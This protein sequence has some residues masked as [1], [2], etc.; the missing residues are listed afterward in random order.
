MQ[1]PRNRMSITCPKGLQNQ[2]GENNCFLNSAVQVLWH[3]DVFR[4][5]FRILSGHACVGH[6]CIFCALKVIFTQFQYSDQTVLPPDQLRKALADTFLDQQRFQVGDM[7]DAAECFENILYQIH[8]H[9]ANKEPEDRCKAPHCVSHQKFGMSIVEQIICPCGAKNEPFA[10]NQLVLYVPTS[11][12][13]SQAKSLIESEGSYFDPSERFS[14]LVGRAMRSGDVRDCPKSCGEKVLLN[15]S[16]R[17]CPDVVSVGLVWDTDRPS[18]NYIMDIGELIGTHLKLTDLYNHV[19]NEYLHETT[20]E[21]VGVVAYYGKHYS[22]F[23]RHTH[24]KRWIYFDDAAIQEVGDQWQAVIDKCC[25]S[26]YQPLLLLYANPE[27]TVVNTHTAPQTTTIVPRNTFRPHRRNHSRSSSVDSL[28]SPSRG[29]GSSGASSDSTVKLADAARRAITP[30]PWEIQKHSQVN[31]PRRRA[32]TPGPDDIKRHANDIDISNRMN[33]HQRQGSF[34]FAVDNNLEPREIALDDDASVQSYQT[35][36]FPPP[37]PPIDENWHRQYNSQ[38]LSPR[39]GSDAG[40]SSSDAGISSGRR[41]KS[42]GRQN[43]TNGNSKPP[44]PFHQRKMKLKSL[45]SE[46]ART[47]NSSTSS[48]ENTNVVSGQPPKSPGI[49][50]KLFSKT[51]DLVRKESFKKNKDKVHA[52]IIRFHMNGAEEARSSPQQ[53]RIA[54]KSNSSENLLSSSRNDGDLRRG[55]KLVSRAQSV[56]GNLNCFDA[57]ADPRSVRFAADAWTRPAGRTCDDSS[58][59]QPSRTYI[60]NG[61]QSLPRPKRSAAKASKSYSIQK[62]DQPDG[63]RNVVIDASKSMSRKNNGPASPDHKNYISRNT[64]EA[65]LMRQGVQAKTAPQG[66]PRS[67]TTTAHRH[68]NALKVVIPERDD[69]SLDSQKDSG[70][71]SGGSAGDRSSASSMSVDSPTTAPSNNGQPHYQQQQQQ[72]YRQN[73]NRNNGNTNSN[74]IYGDVSEFEKKGFQS[75]CEH[76]CTRAEDLM[77]KS[78]RTE[79]SGDLH[80]ALMFCTQ[81]TICLKQAMDIPYIDNQAHMYAQM[82]HNTCVMRTRSLHRRIMMRQDSGNST[83]SSTPSESNSDHSNNP[84]NAVTNESQKQNVNLK[85]PSASSRQRPQ[86]ADTRTARE[87]SLTRNKPNIPSKPASF[88]EHDALQRKSRVDISQANNANA[89]KYCVRNPQ[90]VTQSDAG[91]SRGRAGSLTSTGE[92]GADNSP[93]QIIDFEVNR[94]ADIYAT[95]PKRGLHNKPIVTKDTKHVQAYQDYLNKQRIHNEGINI[96]GGQ[97]QGPSGGQV[98]QA[99]NGQSSNEMLTQ[100]VVMRRRRSADKVKP[101]PPVRKSSIPNSQAVAQAI[102]NM[103]QQAAQQAAQQSAQQSAQQPVQQTAQQPVRQTADGQSRRSN[104]A[105]PGSIGLQD[106]GVQRDYPSQVSLARQPNRADFNNGQNDPRRNNPPESHKDP[107]ANYKEGCYPPASVGSAGGQAPRQQNTAVLP[108]RPQLPDSYQ[109]VSPRDDVAARNAARQANR[110]SGYYP[111]NG[112][113]GPGT[114]QQ[115]AFNNRDQQHANY[116]VYDS[117]RAT[118]RQSEQMNSGPGRPDTAYRHP[119]RDVSSDRSRGNREMPVYHRQN[120]DPSRERYNRERSNLRPTQFCP[121]CGQVETWIPQMQKCKVCDCIS[122]DNPPNNA[123]Y[124]QKNSSSSSSRQQTYIA[125]DDGC[126]SL[127]RR[128]PFKTVRF[129]Q[130]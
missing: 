77:E 72:T 13:V 36:S 112:G 87:R 2:P 14:Q 55:Q 41:T 56:D 82:K 4:R 34:L 122:Y 6:S 108:N 20:F 130:S 80:N 31:P 128:R 64:V 88:S 110:N 22:S 74:P 100:N 8:F 24:S 37:P 65:I 32:V 48:T 121:I 12:L 11:A 66:A 39:D 73:N 52:D 28:G 92:N 33:E 62:M 117:P 25:K 106:R 89:G 97:N 43:S 118:N 35:D 46:I 40:S 54:E 76:L 67:Q 107:Y 50:K 124:Q 53:P 59:P 91:K 1:N 81:A 26:H 126:R 102:S 18:M 68:Q 44:S 3:L 75:Q 111:Q 78:V 93:A 21:L 5:S 99:P 95:L 115:H 119:Q 45:K 10:F 60:D 123:H 63:A 17:N 103:S 101:P 98:T 23:V 127:D 27:G 15:R 58:Y 71:R 109:R 47:R 104:Y 79:E 16:L 7:D 96:T 70:Y 61:Y 30:T 105:D 86:S 94:T 116:G 129:K 85:P 51:K 120:S 29:G 49:S 113:S 42:I 83:M 90:I 57:D 38:H 9:V 19:S 69:T 114:Q 84:S 125:P